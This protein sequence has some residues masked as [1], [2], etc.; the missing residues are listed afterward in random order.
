MSNE[1]K[2]EENEKLAFD[3]LRVLLG[4]V[5]EDRKL[6]LI[7]DAIRYADP[8]EY[9]NEPKSKQEAIRREMFLVRASS[10][11]K[12]KMLTFNNDNY[13]QINKIR[14]YEQH[15]VTRLK[16]QLQTTVIPQL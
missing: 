9:F 4:V 1:I 13:G 2:K 6:M 12:R 5:D 3:Y 15:E 7:Y 14:N 16:M 11:W 8:M 10:Y